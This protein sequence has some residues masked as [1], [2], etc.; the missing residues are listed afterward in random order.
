LPYD[1]IF[2]F[3]FVYLMQ[4]P[5]EYDQLPEEIF[6]KMKKFLKGVDTTIKEK[7]EIFRSIAEYSTFSS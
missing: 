4:N 5:S 6:E 3:D 7:I 2:D 1:G